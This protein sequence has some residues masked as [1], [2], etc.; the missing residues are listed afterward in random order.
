LCTANRLG[1]SFVISPLYF[2]GVVVMPGSLAIQCLLACLQ[3]LMRD[4]KTTV[5]EDTRH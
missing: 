5:T 2:P 3:F 1:E 4:T